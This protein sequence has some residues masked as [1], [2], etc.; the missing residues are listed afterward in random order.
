[1][2][3]KTRT[4]I[5]RS[6]S[7]RKPAPR[8]RKE[9][10]IVLAVFIVA[11]TWRIVLHEFTHDKSHTAIKKAVWKRYS[12][13]GDQLSL[14]LPGEMQS[15]NVNVPENL[16]DKVEQISRYKYDD[17]Q[18]QITVWDMSYFA[19]IPT[20]IQQAAEGARQTL[21]EPDGVEE[22][23]DSITPIIISGRPG[24]R[25]KGT[26]KRSDEEIKLDA[27]LLGDGP[28]LWLVITA[29]PVSDSVAQ[30]ASKTILDSVSLEHT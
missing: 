9:I 16:R 2:M 15:E 12:P 30:A 28:R 8:F 20:D 22:Y 17:E 24:R 4:A 10:L 11:S 5:K 23:Q 13:G 27:V 6:G 25:M 29:Y 19:G 3:K 18:F 1:M 21:S 14:M 26:F 7:K